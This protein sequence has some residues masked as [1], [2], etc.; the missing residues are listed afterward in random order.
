[1]LIGRVEVLFMCNGSNGTPY[2]VYFFDNLYL[3][4]RVS[5]AF[6]EFLVSIFILF[7]KINVDV[8]AFSGRGPLSPA[9]GEREGITHRV[10]I[11]R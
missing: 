6:F 3:I 1:M 4:F 9:V 8:V 2:D 11:D 5:L 7:S 10:M